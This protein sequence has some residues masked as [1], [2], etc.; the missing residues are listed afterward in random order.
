LE[1]TFP[2]GQLPTDLTFDGE[3]V[4]VV[5]NGDGT[6]MRLRQSDGAIKATYPTDPLRGDILFDG[7]SIWVTC[8][9][10]NTVDKITLNQH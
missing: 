1:G 10:S 9:N 2:V 6:V 8:F 5:N 3:Y 4:W 7:T